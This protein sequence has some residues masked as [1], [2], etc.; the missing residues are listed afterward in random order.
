MS[1]KKDIAE[2]GTAGKSAAKVEQEATPENSGNKTF[3]P[4][5]GDETQW[6][7]TSAVTGEN[8]ALLNCLSIMTKLHERPKSIEA[9][10]SNL[11][12]GPEGM[13]PGLYIRA[14]KA[15]GLE[16]RLLKRPLK[17]I[18]PFTLPCTLLFKDKSSAILTRFEG[19][20]VI[21]I[22]PESG[23]ETRLSIQDID[24]RYTGY[25][26]FSN[27][28]YKHDERAQRI[29][30]T[31]RPGHWF[32]GTLWRFKRIYTQ[33]FIAAFFINMFMLT[34]PLFIMNVYDRVVPNSA[35]ESLWIL[36]L[37]AGT[38]FIFD[39]ILR[40]L[41]AYF[42]DIA[43]RGADTL[44]S[45]KLF[46]KLLSLKMSEK[47]PSAGV[48]AGN[49]KEFET[50]REFFTSTT[51]ANL[52]DIPFVL[53]Y[54]L[55]I[56]LIAG[57][58]VLVPL[59]A[60]PIMVTLG[61]LIQRPIT[62]LIRQTYRDVSQKSGLLVEAITGLETL[63]IFRGE[64]AVQRRWENYVGQA[65]K[66]QSQVQT[67]STISMNLSALIANL[68]TVFTIVY[69]VY[70][71]KDGDAT[72][73]SLVAA[74]LL[75][76]RV[77]SPISQLSGVLTRMNQARQSYIALT[78]FMKTREERDESKRFLHRPALAG[79][80]EF[81][82]VTFSYPGQAHEAL[83]NVSF[84]MRRG[85]KVAIIGPIG[86]GK[87]TIEKLLLNLY[88]P[89]KGSV[90]VDGTDVR[91]IDPA[92]LRKNIGTV[93]QDVHLFY[94]NVRDNITL[95]SPEVDD[96]ALIRAAAIAGVT[97]FLRHDDQGFDRMIGERG[98]SLSGG[99]RQAVAIARAL[100]YDP[101]MMILDEPTA[102]MDPGSETMFKKRLSQ[103][104]K[105]KTVLLITHRSA[106]LDLVDRII[107]V[108][109]GKIVADGPKGKVLE[110]LKNK[111][112]KAKI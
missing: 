85:E 47:P 19:A 79:Y 59:V 17:K 4:N 64:G 51:I 103:I 104:I 27:P 37:G 78:E 10:R 98:E 66:G 63:K 106:M 3:V 100:V 58:L 1:E 2:L 22:F 13:T 108:S 23:G 111:E 30:D 76:G 35:V 105:E 45:A 57:P 107:V 65:A 96:N 80:I 72:M 92:D 77:M 60:I 70:L 31:H 48:L 97:D 20:D 46:S 102:S 99:Q 88:E 81:K 82:D 53:I 11:P 9:L 38:V 43:A 52:V 73:G 54:L 67:L 8:D 86:S 89:S 33:V 39:F 40:S 61:Y 15:A 90:C 29:A 75:S 91:Q 25:A 26:L 93:P 95:S 50:I 41:R 112:I 7:V 74:V 62:H 69:G 101:P 68:V 18:S 71:I 110:N 28:I 21:V 6:Q 24:A 55:V 34:T 56:W 42:L 84:S 16:T 83:K 12:V 32:W 44:I 36:A 109:N 87:T 49:M 94:G 14:A 5:P